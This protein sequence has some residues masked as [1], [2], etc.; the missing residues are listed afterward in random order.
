[1]SISPRG[2]RR[3]TFLGQNSHGSDESWQTRRTYINGLASDIPVAV[4][5]ECPTV[6]LVLYALKRKSFDETA[7]TKFLSSSTY[8]WMRS[9][10]FRNL[11]LCLPSNIDIFGIDIPYS[12]SRNIN[13]MF[14]PNTIESSV[15]QVL[16]NLLQY[17]KIAEEVLSSVTAEQ[18]EIMM[19]DKLSI[20]LEANYQEVVVI[21]HN[22][23]ATKYSWLSYRSLCQRIIEKHAYNIS[24]NSCGIFSKDMIF[25]ATPDGRK[26]ESF[27]ISD[28]CVRCG[29]QYQVKMVS[30]YYRSE[31]S[32]ALSMSVWVPLHF[33]EVIVY[34]SG[35][36]I[37]ME[38]NH[39]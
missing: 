26:L 18:R 3:I 24:V 35:H 12:I 9:V 31:E 34:P 19:T 1:M 4:V 2:N 39:G 10:E 29:E 11:L 20:I 14:L 37:T 36:P 13:C 15:R 27:R 8:W 16:T 30:S 5:V 22:F 17:D 6:D 28:A 21:C 23:H 25:I 38:S 32:D 33:D 7:M